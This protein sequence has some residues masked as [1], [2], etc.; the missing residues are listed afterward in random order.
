MLNKNDGKMYAYSEKLLKIAM[1][2]MVT[3]KAANMG[4][5]E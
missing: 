2:D 1:G 5:I 4:Q 3:W